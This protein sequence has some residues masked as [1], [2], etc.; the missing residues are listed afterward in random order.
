MRTIIALAAKDV[1]VLAHDPA[2]VFFAAFF[3]LAVAIFFGTIFAGAGGGGASGMRVAVVDQD[4]TEGSRTFIQTLRDA[5]ELEVVDAVGDAGEAATPIAGPEAAD[6]VRRGKVA[7]YVVLPEGFGEARERMFWGRPP[8]FE[9]G[10]DPSRQAEAAMLQGILT[11]R[12]FEGM[13]EFFTDPSR[14]RKQMQEGR[15]WLTE[16]ASAEELGFEPDVLLRFFDGLDDLMERVPPQE[17]AFGGWQP[18]QMEVK[19]VAFEWEGPTSSYHITFPQGVIWAV[20]ACAATFG[21]SL[22]VERTSGTLQRLRAAPIGR[23]HILAG[24]SL[25]CFGSTLAVCALVFAVG[26]AAFG[27]RPASV[28]LLALA[29]V[30]SAACFVGVMMGVSVI[31]KTERSAAGFGW[32]VVLTMA[33]VGGASMPLFFMP[34]WLKA[35]SRFSPVRWAIYAMEG[36]VWRGF[37]LREMLLPCGILL[38]VG[39]LFYV[40]GVLA[41][42]WVHEG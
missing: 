13:Q 37:T 24:K 3:P 29:V 32:A 11:R 5:P 33:M 39:A 28:G 12:L 38:G 2:A 7:A 41:F 36:A 14:M 8:E 19:E 31:G 18:V 25:A 17:G 21:V 9:V 30:C 6:M 40:L 34:P 23:W 27:V 1:R 10:I 20:L 35:V 4:R 22:V 16:E 26:A 42:R 15:R